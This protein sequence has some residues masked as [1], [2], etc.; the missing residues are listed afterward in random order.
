MAET[1][2][3][4][5]E[6]RE[7]T[8]RHV[9]QLR[10]DGKVPVVIYG[11]HVEPR[12][13]TV[14]RGE[15]EKVYRKAGRSAMVKMKLPDEEQ[16]VLIHDIQRDPRTGRYLHADL[17]QVKMDEK[18]K[19]TVPIHV[20]GESPA[21]RE[22]E[23]IL[24]TNLNELEIECLPGDLPSEITVDISGLADF[25]DAISVADLKIPEGVEVLSEE[26][27]NVVA[28]QA[29]KTEEQLEAELAEDTGEMEEPEVEGEEGAEGEGEEGA[30]SEGDGGSDD[31]AQ[32]DDKDSDD[33]K[34]DDKDKKE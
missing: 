26:E 18:I 13:L 9:K 11:H 21:V 15:L 27:T 1:Y 29:P 34:S 23:G 17:F 30:E 22:K 4:K 8:G 6:P 14:V 7:I 3:L 5:A 10:R 31:A 28:I 19:A 33:N 24:V 2:S 25:D 32:S 20:E 12:N 16:T